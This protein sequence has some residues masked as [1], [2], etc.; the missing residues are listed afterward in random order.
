MPKQSTPKPKKKLT[1]FQRNAI[2]AGAGSLATSMVVA[3]IEALEISR[4]SETFKHLKDAT[5]FQKFKS[6]ANP[7][8]LSRVYGAVPLKL[9]KVLPANII[10]FGTY[11]GTKGYLNKRYDIVKPATKTAMFGAA[12]SVAKNLIPTLRSFAATLPGRTAFKGQ[13]LLTGATGF[14]KGKMLSTGGVVGMGA[15]GAVFTGMS[16]AVKQ[17]V[18]KQY[19]QTQPPILQPFNKR[20]D[21]L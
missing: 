12:I 5:T 15:S 14:G 21:N 10:M 18:L 6:M 8:V 19:G 20:M 1:E 3:P 13:D 2:S 17:P 11:E 7:K 4:A 9:S 16:N